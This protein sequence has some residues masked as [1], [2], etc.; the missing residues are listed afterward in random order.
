MIL[1]TGFMLVLMV[2]KTFYKI[3]QE[4]PTPYYS[5]LVKCVLEILRDLLEH[6][7]PGHFICS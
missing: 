6:D 1:M 7:Y 4:T 2:I 5:W 3:Y